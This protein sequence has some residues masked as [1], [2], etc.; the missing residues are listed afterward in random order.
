[1]LLRA[2][3]PYDEVCAPFGLLNKFDKRAFVSADLYGP[4][5]RT[6]ATDGHRCPKIRRHLFEKSGGPAGAALAAEAAR[7]GRPDEGHP[8]DPRE[9]AEVL[10]QEGHRLEQ[11]HPPRN[12]QTT[13]HLSRYAR[14]AVVAQ[15]QSTRLVTEKSWVRIPQGV[16]LFSFLSISCRSLIRFLVE[17]QRLQI[18]PK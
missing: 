15:G 2:K 11:L 16:E 4:N 14:A 10:A 7:E 13:A 6:A 9:G 5:V 12:L 8:E 18:F 3:W 1:M 17:V